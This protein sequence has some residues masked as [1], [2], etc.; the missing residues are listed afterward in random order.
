MLLPDLNIIQNIPNKER[1]KVCPFKNTILNFRAAK[2]TSWIF[3]K[4]FQANELGFILL[5]QQL[6][7]AVKTNRLID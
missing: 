7:A 5:N 2:K 3:E 6:V 1:T 4:H